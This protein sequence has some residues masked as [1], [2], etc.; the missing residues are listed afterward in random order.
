MAQATRSLQEAYLQWMEQ[1]KAAEGDYIVLMIQRIIQEASA[2]RA[3][4]VH[5]QPGRTA[6]DVRFRLDGVLYKIGE[7]PLANV[8]QVA[9]RIKVLSNLTTFKTD[10]PQEGRIRKGLIPYVDR[11]I[12]ISTAPS[13]YGERIV[14]RFFSEGNRF[15]LPLELG[16]SPEI[17]RDLSLAV[18]KTSGAILIT[19]PAGNGKTTTVCALLRALVGME[20]SSHIV[21]SI[22]SL[23]DPIE[24]AIDGVSQMEV[25]RSGETTLD[26]LIRYLLRQDPDVIM[27]GEIRDR[28]TAEAALQAA[29]TGHLILS[30]FHASDTSSAMCRLLELGLEPFTIRS[31]VSNILNQR[32]V[33]RLCPKCAKK[34][35]IPQT[36]RIL[37]EDIRFGSW[38][39]P[40]GCT[41]CLGTG[42]TGRFLIAESLPVNANEMANAILDRKDASTIR[43]IASECGMISL[44]QA[45]LQLIQS[46]QTSPLEILRVLGG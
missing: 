32:L 41:H 34:N 9:A 42:Y 31:S 15:Q 1:A 36:M 24:Y 35:N 30:T 14:A 28:P 5:L 6:I 13:L 23:E 38:Y 21:R 18:Q 45:A 17:L 4:D 40:V 29:L 25:S 19:G 2:R 10:E 46:G 16:F 7:L 26:K 8:A 33:R 12:R 11:D 3:S 27:I 44:T 39:E 20:N 22:I 43:R 37:N